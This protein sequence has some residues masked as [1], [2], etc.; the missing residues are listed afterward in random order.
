[1]RRMCHLFNN[2]I[3]DILP[4]DSDAEEDWDL[5]DMS[6]S[7]TIE[8]QSS[9]C[10]E[11]KIM[12][13]KCRLYSLDVE[14]HSCWRPLYCPFEA[15]VCRRTLPGVETI[16][17]DACVYTRARRWADALMRSTFGFDI[18]KRSCYISWRGAWWCS[19]AK[20]AKIWRLY[21]NGQVLRGK[22]FMLWSG[23]LLF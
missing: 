5:P 20:Q 7:G 3:E 10:S 21:R 6:P 9:L 8:V 23:I 2:V 22:C 12:Q 17:K 1:M 4:G 11:F 16:S 18:M 13:E 15:S 19:D 14:H